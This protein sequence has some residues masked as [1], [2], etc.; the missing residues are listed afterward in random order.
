MQ[1]AN[2][3]LKN[4]IR[5]T[6]HTLSQ[7]PAPFR[8]PST[9]GI[10]QHGE[11]QQQPLAPLCSLVHGLHCPG[12]VRLGGVTGPLDWMEVFPPV[13]FLLS[14]TPKL[15]RTPKSMQRSNL[16]LHNGSQTVSNCSR[17]RF[18]AAAF[19]CLCLNPWTRTQASLS[20]DCVLQPGRAALYTNRMPDKCS[21]EQLRL[22]SLSF[23]LGLPLSGVTRVG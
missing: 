5:H 9:Y 1:A 17:Q 7:S 19:L 21:I 15:N 4:I 10:Q 14:R 23:S 12:L 16:T 22:L 18:P 20:F 3:K 2:S 6:P 13:S 11:Q 8:T